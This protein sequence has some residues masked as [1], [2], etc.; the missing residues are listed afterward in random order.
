MSPFVQP[1][2][3]ALGSKQRKGSKLRPSTSDSNTHA[4]PGVVSGKNKIGAFLLAAPGR[5]R[6]Y[7]SNTKAVT[8]TYC[9]PLEP[10]L[11]GECVVCRL[12][13]CMYSSALLIV[14]D[15]HA[16]ARSAQH[17]L[18]RAPVS[19]TT[20]CFGSPQARNYNTVLFT[21]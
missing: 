17:V 4:V 8:S 18:S 1:R 11:K 21:T 16:M 12:Q 2:R 19:T 14:G 6:L 7:A 10:F 3:Q 5:H 15:L 13:I 20:Q 9:A